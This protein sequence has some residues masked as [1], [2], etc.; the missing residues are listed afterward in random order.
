M[1]VRGSNPVRKFAFGHEPMPGT[2]MALVV[3]G[4]SKTL[5]FSGNVRVCH[6][7]DCRNVIP[8]KS[9]EVWDSNLL[10]ASYG[11][12]TAVSQLLA[13]YWLK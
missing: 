2:E 4:L 11:P 12:N 7:T 13:L 9:V 6:G 5:T 1:N 8:S 3:I 10:H